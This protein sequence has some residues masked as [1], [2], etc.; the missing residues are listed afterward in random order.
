MSD[1]KPCILF[2]TDFGIG[3]GVQMYGVC[4][5][6][7]PELEL[8]DLS[9]TIPTFNVIAASSSLRSVI[10]F[11]PEGTVFVSVVD[12]GVGTPRR[13]SVALLENGCYVVTP[14]NGT[15][16]YVQDEF[17]VKA[18]R[19]IDEKVNRY[20]GTEKVSIFHGRDLFAYC[21]ARLAAGVI[22]FEGVGPEYPVDEIVRFPVYQGNVSPGSA[23]GI[24]AESMKTFGNLET[25][26]RIEDFE[27]TGIIH[28]DKVRVTIKHGDT[29]VFERDM[30]FHKSFGF[31]PVGDCVA[32]NS[33]S[34][35]IGVAVNQGN[36]TETY[37]I[38]SGPDWHISI[39]KG[40]QM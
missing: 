21:A 22:D 23:V 8:Y 17:G 39:V 32:F 34:G 7:D 19:E 1:Y 18:I 28:G 25:N 13:A 4:K 36:F 26:I 12:P 29:P 9:H 2:Q 14:D 37:G 35:F 10:P 16:T 30:L 3:G 6:V 31:C 38:G 15:L 5:Q 33:S 20:K 40:V 11:W 27:K 24:C